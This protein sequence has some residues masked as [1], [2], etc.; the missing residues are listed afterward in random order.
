[1]PVDEIATGCGGYRECE[2]NSMSSLRLLRD[3]V[4][5]LLECVTR[6]QVLG[7]AIDNEDVDEVRERVVGKATLEVSRRHRKE[8][9][10]WAALRE[11][12]GCGTTLLLCIS[13]EWWSVS[14]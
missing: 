8:S 7:H 12:V 11:A 10:C 6:C 5:M 4:D 9:I 14:V 2:P 3:D 13:R 1:M